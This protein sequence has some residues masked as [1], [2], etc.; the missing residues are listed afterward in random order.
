MV[1]SANRG[2]LESTVALLFLS[3]KNEVRDSARSVA[4][5]LDSSAEFYLAL[6]SV[7]DSVDSAYWV[8]DTVASWALGVS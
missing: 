5:L 6:V 8:E 3:R 4:G 2:E 1:L 7:G